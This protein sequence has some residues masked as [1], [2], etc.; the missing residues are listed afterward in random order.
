MVHSPGRRPVTPQVVEEVSR[1]SPVISNGS[2]V[3]KEIPI[4]ITYPTANN[5]D[6]SR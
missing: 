1:Q 4:M 2:S 5:S 6:A 3:T